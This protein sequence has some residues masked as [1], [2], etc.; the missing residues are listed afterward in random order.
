MCLIIYYYKIQELGSILCKCSMKT[1]NHRS[2]N[3][4]TIDQWKVEVCEHIYLYRIS[5]ISITVFPIWFFS[6]PSAKE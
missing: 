3:C 6:Y 4:A 5:S 2:K 1:A